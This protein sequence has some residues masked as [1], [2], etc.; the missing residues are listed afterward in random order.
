MKTFRRSGGTIA[1][2][3]AYCLLFASIVITSACPK[4]DAVRTAID[5]S[6]R[7]PATTNDLIAKVNEAKTKGF[8]TADQSKKFGDLLSPL[9]R[10]EVVYV[11][12]VKA[13]Q[14]AV[15][16]NGTA[17]P[18]QLGTLKTFFDAQVIGPFL[19]ILEFCKVLSGDSVQ[20]I[21]VAV[22]GVRL[23]LRTIG[24][25]IGSNFINALAADT[26]GPAAI[27]SVA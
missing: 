3:V 17:D 13:L 2:A 22:S 4:K 12:M 18:G 25:G 24:L 6:Y 14:A 10:A 5:A 7:L 16:A 21:L 15:K 20:V 11:G 23:L 9:A 19:Q 27:G 26:R 1:F 8:I